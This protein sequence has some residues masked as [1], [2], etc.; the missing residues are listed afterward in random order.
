MNGCVG[1]P[2]LIQ[3]HPA[4]H[5]LDR[6]L[7]GAASVVPELELRRHRD[8]VNLKNGIEKLQFK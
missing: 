8:E 6:H 7:S 2:T 4:V 3:G 5:Q 1:G